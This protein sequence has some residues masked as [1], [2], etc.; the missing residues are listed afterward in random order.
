M[1][2]GI[3]QAGALIPVRVDKKI[4]DKMDK[5]YETLNHLKG[6]TLPSSVFETFLGDLKENSVSKMLS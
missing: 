4:K 5:L 3:N 1:Q 2:D 6:L